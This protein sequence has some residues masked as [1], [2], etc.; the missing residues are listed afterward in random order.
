MAGFDRLERKLGNF[1]NALRGLSIAAR[2]RWRC[3]W[4]LRCGSSGIC[5]DTARGPAMARTGSPSVA[6]GRDSGTQA[7][8]AQRC[9]LV[10]VGAARLVRTGNRPARG[11]MRGRAT[12]ATTVRLSAGSVPGPRT[13][14]RDT[15][16]RSCCG[17]PR[18]GRGWRTLAERHMGIGARAVR[19]GPSR[20]CRWRC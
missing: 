5:A 6:D 17:F 9:G 1:R 2:P 10:G 14:N 19:P 11:G 7:A 3:A 13:G 20:A 18:A 4:R 16:T 12:F 15:R 8:G